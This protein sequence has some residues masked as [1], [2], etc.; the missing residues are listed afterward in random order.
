M[1][2]GEILERF[3]DGGAVLKGHFVLA[4]EDHSGIYLEKTKAVISS[5]K[6]CYYSE[7]IA[8][9]WVC[10]GIEAVVGPATAGIKTVSGGGCQYGRMSYSRR[11]ERRKSFRRN[12][13]RR[14][15]IVTRHNRD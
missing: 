14:E 9:E 2:D 15:A 1:S 10:E 13:R 4:G 11:Q 6:L 8:W 7:K 5:S 12:I 3:K